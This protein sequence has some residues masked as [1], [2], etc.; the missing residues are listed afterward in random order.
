MLD[1]YARSI[2]NKFDHDD[3]IEVDIQEFDGK[4]IVN[5]KILDRML[6]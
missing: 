6:N 5:V 4:K 3:E 2:L 1:H